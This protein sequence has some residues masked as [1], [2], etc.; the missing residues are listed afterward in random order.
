M[1]MSV[2]GLTVIAIVLLAMAGGV[3]A[4]VASR[5][6]RRAIREAPGGAG[7]H[8]ARGWLPPTPMR[9]A[10]LQ[11]F[12]SQRNLGPATVLVLE[13]RGGRAFRHFVEGEVPYR[14]GD[15]VLVAGQALGTANS[16]GRPVTDLAPAEI[17][18]HR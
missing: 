6:A 16:D 9:V 2:M 4:I 18:P 17:V 5:G 11:Q 12:A 1:G 8:P 15:E 10:S 3:I 14:V 13:D 7:G